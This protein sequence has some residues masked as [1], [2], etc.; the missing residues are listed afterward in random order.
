LE[1]L[2]VGVVCLFSAKDIPVTLDFC[3]LNFVAAPFITVHLTKRPLARRELLLC[4]LTGQ[5]D[6]F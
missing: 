5:S 1:Q 4:C 2:T 3:A 6:E